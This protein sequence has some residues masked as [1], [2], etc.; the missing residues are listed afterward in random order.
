M[1]NYETHYE[2]S[3]MF[4]MSQVDLL[5]TQNYRMASEQVQYSHIEYIYVRE[6]LFPFVLHSRK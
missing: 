3:L 4:L 1:F 2:V 6:R 5:L